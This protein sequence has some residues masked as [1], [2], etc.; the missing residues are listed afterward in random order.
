MLRGSASALTRDYDLL[1]LDLD[2]VVYVGSSAVAGAVESLAEAAQTGA[3]RCFATNNASRTPTE[4]AGHLAELGLPASAEDVITSSQ[5]A[6]QLVLER[7][8]PQASVLTVGG[9]GVGAA[10]DE[11]GLRRVRSA[12]DSPNAVVQGYGRDVGWVDLAEATYA[13]RGGAWWV[14]T[15]TD[16][17]LPTERGPAPGNGTLVAAV[18]AA[19]GVEPVVAGKPEPGLF[20]TAATRASARRPL[21]VGDRLDTDLA[22]AVSAGQDGLLVLTGVSRPLDVLE[23]PHDQRPVYL[24]EDL[25]G[26]LT[27]HPEPVPR[28]GAW[29]CRDAVVTLVDGR[30]EGQAPDGRE[31]SLDLLRAACAAVWSSR[32]ARVTVS[33]E[34]DARWDPL[35]RG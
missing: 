6:A 20:L 16:A 29:S 13:V 15:N 19:V 27:A 35:G 22:G 4:V 12:D 8:G 1:I 24:A 14:A 32:P 31:H 11:L 25:G 10:C 21:V 5:A 34:L 33:P 3:R 23:A 7:L 26:L 2:G 17:T 28:D 9:P 30:L 18:R